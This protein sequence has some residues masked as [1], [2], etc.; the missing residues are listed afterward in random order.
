MGRPAKPIEIVMVDGKKHLTKEEIE[1]RRKA[2]EKLRNKVTAF[3]ASERVKNNP[4]AFAMFK[5]L[6]KLY[7]DAVYVDGADEQIINRYCL[8]TAEIDSMEALLDR[9]DAAV[10][11]C[12]EPKQMVEMYKSITGMTGN[13]KSAREML[14]KMEDRMLLNPTARI[15]NV[16]KKIK[17]DKPE[18]KF[19][20]F[21]GAQSG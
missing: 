21:G 19:N 20:R 14:L 11:K 16:P 10:D 17:D 18:S 2:Q 5:K 13:I 4:E 3:R 7:K 1:L 9:M 12:E 6:K 8:L 15:K